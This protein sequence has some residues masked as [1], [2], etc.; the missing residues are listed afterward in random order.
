MLETLG[1]AAADGR[2][3]RRPAA[4]RQVREALNGPRESARMRDMIS[5]RLLG[6]CMSQA[7]AGRARMPPPSEYPVQTLT[8][9]CPAARVRVPCAVDGWMGGGC[10]A[11]RQLGG[12]LPAGRHSQEPRRAAGPRQPARPGRPAPVPASRPRSQRGRRAR[13]TQVSRHTPCGSR[14]PC[15]AASAML[16][17]RAAAHSPPAAFAPARGMR[18]RPA[19]AAPLP[20]GGA[21]PGSPRRQPSRPPRPP[22]RLRRRRMCTPAG[23]RSLRYPPRGERSRRGR[24]PPCGAARTGRHCARRRRQAFG[25]PGLAA[26]LGSGRGRALGGIRDMLDDGD[27]GRR[28]AVR[29]QVDPEPQRRRVAALQ[30]AG[31]H[32]GRPIRKSRVVISGRPRRTPFGRRRGNIYRRRVAAAGGGGAPRRRRDLH[33]GERQAARVPD[34]LPDGRR[35]LAGPHGYT[36]VQRGDANL[37]HVGLRRHT[38][39]VARPPWTLAVCPLPPGPAAHRHG[40][41]VSGW[42][43][44]A[45]MESLSRRFG[46]HH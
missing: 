29:G 32:R 18:P 46:P 26:A 3:L 24:P 16:P 22:R 31:H 40:S 15:G 7:V 8:T 44:A 10:P 1:G 25:R 43:M 27:A 34:I 35:I 2:K 20:G 4:P 17:A 28:A 30:P 36:Q 5:S 45:F 9:G 11:L 13:R 14:R 6:E 19:A 12:R 37:A 41:W 38:R 33:G 42:H 23:A 21:R 39:P